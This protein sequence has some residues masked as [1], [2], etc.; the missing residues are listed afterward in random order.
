MSEVASWTS[1]RSCDSGQVRV[2]IACACVQHRLSAR[3]ASSGKRRP[4]KRPGADRL[5]SPSVCRL[6]PS[7]L[8]PLFPPC[9]QVSKH[10]I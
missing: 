5:P 4:A 8:Q 10:V 6:F 3:P 9:A 7:L 2:F 1:C